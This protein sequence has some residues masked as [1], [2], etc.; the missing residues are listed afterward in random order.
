VQNGR[1]LGQDCPVR[2]A[3]A[4]VVF[5]L[6]AVALG[7]RTARAAEDY[8]ASAEAR[9]RATVEQP[10]LY[11]VDPH[12]PGARQVLAGYALAFSSSGGAIRPIPG[13]FDAEG[14]AHQLSLEVGALPWLRI[15]GTTMIA[16]AI[17]TSEVGAVALQAGAR[18]LLTPASWQRFR[19]MINAAFLREFGSDVGVL[20]ELT[21]TYDLGRVRLAAS[22]HA[23]RLFGQKRDAVDL[24]AVAGV[25]V[26]V[27][28][29]LRLGVE[30][31]AQDLEDAF[32]DEE[33]EGGARHYVGPD[34]ALSLHRDRLLLTAGAAVQASSV[35]G[36][37]ARAALTYVY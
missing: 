19:L 26:R 11:M 1:G 28:P 7:D 8:P 31:V 36:V 29:I 21:G 12:G 6:A 25:S 10:F 35:P 4:A 2:I 27:I 15:Y 5:A 17:G 16:Q 34:V 24:Y 37:L 20:G 23:E 9:P 33:A 22:M 32:E 13:H 14:V 30:Y 3:A 18:A